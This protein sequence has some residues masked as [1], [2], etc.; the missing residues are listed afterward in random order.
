MRRN[1]LASSIAMVV[2]I[3]LGWI[4]TMMSTPILWRLEPILRTEMAA[5][6]EQAKAK[7]LALSL[8]GTLRYVP[9][10]ALHDGKRYLVERYALS[11]YTE[12]ARSNLLSFPP[13]RT[14]EVA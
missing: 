12:A 2:G 7:T 4:L 9:F 14:S 8:D 3:P 11:V 13:P 10:A 1:L 5:D 6:L